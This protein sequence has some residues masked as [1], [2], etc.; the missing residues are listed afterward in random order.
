MDQAPLFLALGGA[1]LPCRVA[2]STPTNGWSGWASRMQ[3]ILPA[4][5]RERKC[6]QASCT[7]PCHNRFCH[8]SLNIYVHDYTYTCSV[9]LVDWKGHISWLQE[10]WQHGLKCNITGKNST[11]KWLLKLHSAKPRT[12]RPCNAR[13][14]AIPYIVNRQCINYNNQWYIRTQKWQRETWTESRKPKG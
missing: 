5:G 14:I 6:E 12:I 8:V 2:R 3:R 7:T 11:S 9:P 1:D 13:Y 4:E 10:E